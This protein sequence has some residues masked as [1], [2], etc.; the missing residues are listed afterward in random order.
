MSMS[1]SIV[2]TKDQ[3]GLVPR[4][5]QAPAEGSDTGQREAREEEF[6]FT[7]AVEAG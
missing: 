2:L 3:P 4:R 7:Q 1:M 6:Q 5:H